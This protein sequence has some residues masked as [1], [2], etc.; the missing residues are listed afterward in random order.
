MAQFNDVDAAARL[1]L[2]SETPDCQVGLRRMVQVANPAVVLDSLRRSS[3]SALVGASQRQL[4]PVDPGPEGLIDLAAF[5]ELG[6][7]DCRLRAAAWDY[8]HGSRLRSLGFWFF[9]PDAGQKFILNY[10]SGGVV[11]I[12]RKVRLG[13]LMNRFYLQR[14]VTLHITDFVAQFRAATPASG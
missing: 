12:V 6:P 13:Q 3:L 11:S 1:I 2:G 10:T 5:D 7:D 14:I 8:E 4:T 9:Y